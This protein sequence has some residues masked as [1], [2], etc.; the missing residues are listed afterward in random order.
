MDG[1][2][3]TI[4]VFIQLRRLYREAQMKFL[5][6]SPEN[7]ENSPLYSV[8]TELES[9]E[10]SEF[11]NRDTNKET[12]PMDFNIMAT[13]DSEENDVEKFGQCTET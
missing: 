5:V 12:E 8:H 6:R 13:I 11:K 7:P 10:G 1:A 3:A 9:L 2:Y 4:P